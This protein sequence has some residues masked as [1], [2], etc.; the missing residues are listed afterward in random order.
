MQINHNNF[1]QVGQPNLITL[2]SASCITHG[3]NAASPDQPAL[4]Y[5]YMSNTN[6]LVNAPTPA[7][8]HPPK[9]VIP[10]PIITEPT[11][12][13]INQNKLIQKCRSEILTINEYELRQSILGA[14]SNTELEDTSRQAIVDVIKQGH[15]YLPKDYDEQ[16][17]TLIINNA[18]DLI[19]KNI[20]KPPELI[21][22]IFY[23]GGKMS[24][25]APSKMGKTWSLMHLALAVSE[26][27]D[28]FGFKTTKSRI[29]FI[30]P[31]LQN[32]SFEDRIQT[33]AR[34]FNGQPTLENFDYISTRGLGLNSNSLIPLLERRIKAG[35]YKA[36]FLDSIYKL[37]PENVEENSSSD[38]G[39]F[40]NELEQLANNTNAA[41][42]YSHHY[43]KGLQSGKAA[44]DRSSGAGAWG[45]DPDAIISVTEHEKENTYTVE[46]NLR[47]FKPVQPI[48]IRVNWPNVTR[49]NSLN[50]KALKTT[51]YASKYTETNILDYLTS[52]PYTAS[53]LQK[54]LK[55]ELGMSSSTFYDL[56]N[57]VKKK[58]GVGQDND[59]KWVYNR[60]VCNTAN[61]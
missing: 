27:V 36:I 42:V 17:D 32:F 34:N 15:Q 28:W 37:Y 1:G 19:V 40:L 12:D 8:T 10:K 18:R 52:K 9:L 43:S 55:R 58:P 33:L 7:I 25:N 35:Q 60:Q 41:I 45:R 30:N 16:D 44:I 56:W 26:G 47:D 31:E 20:T 21:E 61:N 54:E 24:Y 51:Q 38:V 3:P 11:L 2:A 50:P 49:D 57:E 6:T 4:D 5:P 13:Q 23:V 48:A 46:F 14:I 39:R 22:G 29:L 53:E 59:K